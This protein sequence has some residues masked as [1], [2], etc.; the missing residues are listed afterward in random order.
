MG[1]IGIKLGCTILIT[2]LSCGVI[3]GQ[4]HSRR[5]EALRLMKEIQAG[6]GKTTANQII[7]EKIWMDRADTALMLCTPMGEA[8]FVLVSFLNGKP[9]LLAYA[10]EGR[11]SGEDLP[12]GFLWLTEAYLADYLSMTE[13]ASRFA[14]DNS[15][16]QETEA[17]GAQEVF[18]LLTCTWDQRCL[19]NDSC[20]ADVTSPAYFCGRAPAGCVATTMA[21]IMKYHKWPLQG[22]GTKSYYNIKYGT[23]NANFGATQYQINTL[24][25]AIYN[26]H[27]G[28]ARLL[29]HAGIASQMNYGPLA[30]GTGITDARYA[31][32][33]YFGYKNTAQVVTKSSYTDAAWKTLMRSEIDAGRPVFYSGIEQNGGGGHAWVL[34]GYSFNDFFHFNWGWSG[35]ANGYFTLANLNPLGGANYVNYQEAIIGIEPAGTPPLASF[36][37]SKVVLEKGDSIS[38]TNLSSSGSVNFQ[39]FFPGGAPASWQG[40]TP[41]PVSYLAGGTYD[42]I[43]IAG[44]GLTHDTMH[45]T[46]YLR[47][48]PIAGFNASRTVTQAGGTVN[49]FDATE[50]NSPM[51]AWEWHFFGGQPSVSTQKNPTGILYSQPGQYAVY[52][53]VSGG[54]QSDSQMVLKYIT[55]HQQCD[56][57]LDFYMQGW[58]V[59]PVNQPAFQVYQEDLDGLP[60]Y[61]STYITS[62]WQ[63]YTETG[64]NQFISATSLFTTPGTANNWL[65]FG[66]VTLPP[67]GAQLSWRHKF[68]DH[69]KR[70]GYEIKVNTSGFTHQQFTGNPLFSLADNDPYTL[71]DTIWRWNELEIPPSPYGGQPCWI[72]IHH[73]AAN[74]FYLAFDDFRI[75]SCNGYPL[76]ADLFSFDTLIAAGDT[77]LFYDFSTGDPLQVSWN[78]PGGI[79][80]NPGAKHPLVKYPNPG[81]YDVVI[82]AQYGSGP[83]TKTYQGYIMVQPTGTTHDAISPTGITLYPNPARD[84]L[85]LKGSTDPARFTITRVNGGIVQQGEVSPGGTI[86]LDQLPAG[87]WF[88]LLQPDKGPQQAFRFVKL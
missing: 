59:Q 52:L 13:D 77:A 79:H 74:M 20:P 16:Q 12:P 42:V 2:V 28:I 38:F 83:N 56:T 30:S 43:L 46:A 82:T 32:V 11:L 8:G 31:L 26:P 47:V 48:L 69:T 62:G 66:P 87:L 49:F 54:N 67:G 60:P 6:Q 17:R 22:T 18:P 55:V 63:Y 23:L 41:P 33:S 61:H 45:R 50:S 35:I 81:T 5:G 65:I 64:G 80:L 3:S 84:R 21:Q 85:W 19:F 57:L 10:T 72:G 7:V 78:F 40:A 39:W 15:L 86:G 24:P 51:Q 88:L 37:A 70:D 53:K 34:D 58:N 25:D 76:T 36:S 73:Y 14:E 29:Y 1:T 4:E 71:G 27:A 68:P 75:T 9:T 44:N